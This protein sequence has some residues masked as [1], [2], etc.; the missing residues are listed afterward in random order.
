MYYSLNIDNILLDDPLL[1]LNNGDHLLYRRF[2]FRK[3]FKPEILVIDKQRRYN[4]RSLGTPSNER[5]D[6]YAMIQCVDPSEI[7][8]CS[9]DTHPEYFL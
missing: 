8:I 4:L 1:K 5:L 9:E 2:S 3:N 7:E 6:E